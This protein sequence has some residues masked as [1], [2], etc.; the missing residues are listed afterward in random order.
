MVAPFPYVAGSILTAAQLNSM[1][2]GVVQS[3]GLLSAT[4]YASPST[5]Q[6][7]IATTVNRLYLTPI[8]IPTTTTFDRIA[9]NSGTTVTNPTTVRL[10]IYSNVAGVPTALVLDAGTVSVT[11]ISSGYE[12]TISKSLDGGWYWL[13]SVNQTAASTTHLYF[14][15]GQS[16]NGITRMSSLTSLLQGFGYNIDGITGALPA[17]LTAPNAVS[18]SPIVKLRK[19]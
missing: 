7:S 15:S 8:Y 5:A 4:Y 17:T 11:A 19:A 2:S 16:G 14:L 10:G 6:T 3:V 12:I 9:I 18:S 13:G 1:E